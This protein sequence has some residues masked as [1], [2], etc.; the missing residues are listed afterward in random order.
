MSTLSQYEFD[1]LMI[2]LENSRVNWQPSPNKRVLQLAFEY[3]DDCR[4]VGK[5]MERR[6]VRMAQV[7]DWLVQYPHSAKARK[8]AVA[9]LQHPSGAFS[10]LTRVANINGEHA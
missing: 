7:H 5:D 3:I 9:L 8:M 6:A 1:R 10:V 4:A 2:T